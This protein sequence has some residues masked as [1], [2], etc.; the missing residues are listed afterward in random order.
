MAG[1]LEALANWKRPGNDLPRLPPSP[2]ILHEPQIPVTGN[3]ILANL[4][5]LL[6]QR[7]PRLG[8]LISR[9][10]TG[11]TQ[12]YLGDLRTLGI[13]DH[14]FDTNDVL[15]AYSPKKHDIY[16]RGDNTLDR[17]PAKGDQFPSLQQVVFHEMAHAE[18][19]NEAGAQRIHKAMDP[20]LHE[21]LY[22][23][24]VRRLNLPQR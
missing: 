19:A 16:I 2:E 9:V 15:G 5:F 12:E 13:P 1:L 7:N 4:V 22:R 21:A 3:P 11:P 17:L 10:Q 14:K 6:Q 20:R 23:Q 24:I 8:R 18:G